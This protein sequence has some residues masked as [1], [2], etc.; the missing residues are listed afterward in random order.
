ML[1]TEIIMGGLG[2]KLLVTG[3]LHSYNTDFLGPQAPAES[4]IQTRFQG[5]SS[6]FLSKRIARPLVTKILML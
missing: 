5:L 4:Y 2:V 6:N 3:C 1:P